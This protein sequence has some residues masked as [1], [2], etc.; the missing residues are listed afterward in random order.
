MGMGTSQLEVQGTTREC[1]C[2]RRSQ[3]GA[4]WVGLGLPSEVP[5][6]A[7]VGCLVPPARWEGAEVD[8]GIKSGLRIFVVVVVLLLN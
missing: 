4:S 3:A 5:P 8:L 6:L 2:P 7:F 1:S